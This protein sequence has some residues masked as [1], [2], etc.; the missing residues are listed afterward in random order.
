MMRTPE[1]PAGRPLEGDHMLCD[2]DRH[3]WRARALIGAT[4]ATITCAM[5][6]ATVGVSPAQAAYDSSGEI[7]FSGAVSGTLHVS[8]SVNS[9]GL[10]GCA[11]AG[12]SKIGST[13]GGTDTM[14][15]DN[16]KLKIHNKLTTIAF[17]SLAVD[18]PDFGRTFSMTPSISSEH[19]GVALLAGSSYSAKSGSA[20]STTGGK[21]GSLKGVLAAA[22]GGSG[23]VTVTGHWAGCAAPRT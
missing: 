18:I 23:T 7:T 3:P 13:V 6:I 20:T 17:V 14:V 19:T 10:P 8:P 16:V 22:G 1:P 11:I 9:G 4:A 12:I 5:A 15:W 2:L 21:S